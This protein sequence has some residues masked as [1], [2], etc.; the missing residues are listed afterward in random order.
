MELKKYTRT[1]LYLFFGIGFAWIAIKYLL[2]ILLPFFIGFA[3]SRIAEPLI[4]AIRKRKKIPRWLCALLGMVAVYGLLGTA[5]FFL[6]RTLFMELQDFVSGL[7]ALLASME[8]PLQELSARLSAL[9]AK[10]PGNAGAVVSEWVENLFASGSVVAEHLSAWL[11]D[12]AAGLVS[13]LPGIVLFL[14]TSVLSSFM[15]SSEWPALRQSLA[16]RLPAKW[17]S[18]ASTLLQR[19]KSAMGGWLKAQAKLT[20][21]SFGL[22]TAGLWILGVDY[23]L[24]FG[25]VIALIDAL[26]VLGVGTVLIPWAILQFMQGNTSLGFG[27]LILY[28]VVS[29]CR[30]AAEPRLL[31]KQ[32][33][34]SPV[35]TLFSMYAGFRLLGVFG[36]ILLPILAIL[37]KQFLDLWEGKNLVQK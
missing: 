4:R 1:A 18:R 17:R 30:S 6:I 19:L 15:L 23:P 34:L 11:V 7:P 5:L 33:G 21:L 14:V 37:A 24:L 13:S 20:L 29:L 12:F 28:G 36:M 25:G 35:I 9:S 22:L 31:G 10:L 26:P 32:V 27:L 16:R 8:G 3:L 2:P